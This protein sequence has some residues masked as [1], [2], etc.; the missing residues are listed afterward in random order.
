MLL[1]LDPPR[2]TEAIS[3]ESVKMQAIQIRLLGYPQVI[4]NG[5]EVTEALSQKALA[6]LVYLCIEGGNYTRLELAGLLWG[7]MND[8]RARANLRSAL[9]NLRQVLPGL[10]DVSRSCVALSPDLGFSLDSRLLAEHASLI[11]GPAGADALI[12][13]N[14]LYRGIPG[15]FLPRRCPG[16][17]SLGTGTA[18]APAVDVPVCTA[19]DGRPGS[20]RR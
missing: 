17:R 3:A 5:S 14:R 15:R 20:Q 18:R 6:L 16:I 12:A 13:F 9:H 1:L 8:N 19:A 11:T 4:L 2:I 7:D 10:V